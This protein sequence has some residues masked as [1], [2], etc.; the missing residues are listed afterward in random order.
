MKIAEICTLLKREL[1]ENNYQYGFYFGGI[2]YMPDFKNGFDE[3]FFKLSKTVY[4]IQNPQDT[5]KEKIGNCID[6]VIVMKIILDEI[7]VPSKIW[8]LYHNLKKTPHTIL[9]FEAEEKLVYLELTPQSNKPLYDYLVFKKTRRIAPTRF[10]I[11]LSVLSSLLVGL[12]SRLLMYSSKSLNFL[13]CSRTGLS[14]EP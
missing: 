6:A 8:L 1:Y 2:K 5:M 4:R 11:Q 14:L 3:E 7:N 13:G 10:V 12:P 9:T